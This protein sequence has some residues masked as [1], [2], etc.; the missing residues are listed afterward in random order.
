MH[1][2]YLMTQLYNFLNSATSIL[3]IKNILRD[4][5][6]VVFNRQAVLQNFKLNR[7]KYTVKY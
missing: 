7:L 3:H 5:L 6:E 1:E 4:K 2:L